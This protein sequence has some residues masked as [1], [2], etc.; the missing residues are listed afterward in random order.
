MDWMQIISLIGG[1]VGGGGLTA[2]VTLKFSRRKAG[3]EA[4]G[5]AI[6]A[7]NNAISTMKG[8][9]NDKDR[10]IADLKA[11]N[12]SLREQLEKV[13]EHLADKRCECTTKGYYMCIHQGCV[14]RRP[15][16]GRGK[17]YFAEHG[18]DV[19][20]GADFDTVEELL[21]EHRKNNVLKMI[22]YDGNG[23]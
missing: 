10:D 18:D 2:L 6:D 14:L 19:D 7:L 9:D 20:F 4:D 21:E 15:A 8:I 13:Q 16:L 12:S 23:K 1:F 17:T 22:E 5:A 3:A 11:E